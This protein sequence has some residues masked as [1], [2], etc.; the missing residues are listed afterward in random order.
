MEKQD[1]TMTQAT[2]DKYAHSVGNLRKTMSNH[3]RDLLTQLEKSVFAGQFSE[4]AQDILNVLIPAYNL[5][6]VDAFNGSGYLYDTENDHHIRELMD[7]VPFKNIVYTC[8]LVYESRKNDLQPLLKYVYISTEYDQLMT[9]TPGNLISQLKDDVDF[10]VK[11]V[12]S[13]P[14]TTEYKAIY[15]MTINEAEDMW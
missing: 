12:L 6:Y 3:L 2:A 4:E 5:M 11:E 1:F 13:C 9:M 10:L 14:W 15:A 7:S 8:H